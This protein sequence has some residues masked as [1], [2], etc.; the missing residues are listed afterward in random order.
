MEPSVYVQSS[1]SITGNKP[2]ETG[3][4][5][6]AEVVSTDP[7]F[8]S[9]SLASESSTP[10]HCTMW[11]A[12]DNPPGL[13]QA[14]AIRT[15]PHIPTYQAHGTRLPSMVNHHRQTTSNYPLT[16]PD[17]FLSSRSEDLNFSRSSLPDSAHIMRPDSSLG[18]GSDPGSRYDF[19][20]GSLPVRRDKI[21]K[22]WWP[23]PAHS[24]SSDIGNK[25]K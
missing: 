17:Q 18:Y 25:F 21:S 5:V 8:G 12:N 6:W 22:I 7:P 14:Q 3:Q 24:S 10:S 19:S 16:S 23:S 13:T 4:V 9:G 20:T 2:V 15:H 1:V 11:D